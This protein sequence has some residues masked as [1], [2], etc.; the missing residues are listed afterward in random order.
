MKKRQLPRIFPSIMVVLLG[1]S[2]VAS[3]QS[4]PRSTG[5][6]WSLLGILSIPQGSYADKSEGLAK[7]GGGLGLEVLSRWQRSRQ[8][9]L[10][11]G[12]YFVHNPVNVDHLED[13]FETMTGNSASVNAD[14]W[15][16]AGLLTGLRFVSS[17]EPGASLQAQAQLGA[18]I[19]S[20][21]DIETRTQGQTIFQSTPPELSLAFSLGAGI[22]DGR[23]GLSVRYLNLGEP[24]FTVSSR[25]SQSGQTIKTSAK[26]EIS[27][28]LVVAEIGF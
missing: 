3:A 22:K 18:N 23:F 21:G 13:V 16:H 8:V 1:L 11:S 28:F 20:L 24:K 4:A 6:G 9:Y 19:A 15:N 5:E 7:L 25:S 14:G 17:V 26:Q 12:G 27:M 10:V 2:A